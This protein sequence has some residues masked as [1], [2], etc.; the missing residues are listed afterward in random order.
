MQRLQELD[1]AQMPVFTDDISVQFENI[2][3]NDGIRNKTTA[4]RTVLYSWILM[5]GADIPLET[6]KTLRFASSCSRISVSDTAGSPS[7]PPFVE[8]QHP[9][10]DA[11]S[12]QVHWHN[13]STTANAQLDYYS[14]NMVVVE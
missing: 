12:L 5:D 6:D 2:Q 8:Q 3:I 4:R 7:S 13:T 11:T 14:Y 1:R 9:M 10:V